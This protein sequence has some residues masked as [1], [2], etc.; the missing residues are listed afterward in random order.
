[1]RARVR[2]CVPRHLSL[3]LALGGGRLL[4]NAIQN[5]MSGAIVNILTDF[6]NTDANAL[7]ASLSLVLPLSLPAPFNIAE[8]VFLLQDTPTI[9]SV[10]VYLVSVCDICVCLCACVY[11]GFMWPGNSPILSVSVPVPV[12]RTTRGK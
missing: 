11:V 3:T 1:M 8:A 5:A 9:A 12:S 4:T 6:V 2:A 7:L 10:R